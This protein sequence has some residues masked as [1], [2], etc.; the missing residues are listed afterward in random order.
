MGVFMK[1]S[2]LLIGILFISGCDNTVISSDE[3]LNNTSW[4][5]IANEGAYGASNG[6]ISMIDDYGNVYETESIGDIV[7]SFEVYNDKLIVIVNNSH[8]IKIYDI[9]PEGLSMPGIEID[10]ENSS[11]R[12]L[13]VLND[14]IY[15]TNWNTQDVKVFDLFNYT[16]EASI[17]TEGLPEDIMFDGTN[18]WVTIT[19][20]SDWSP[21]T[22][23]SKIDINTNSIIETI[24]VGDG[25]QNLIQH[26]GDIYISRT[27][28]DNSWNA[29]HGSSKIG[30]ETIFNNYGSGVVCGGSVLSYN[31]EVYRSHS[32]GISPLKDNLDIDESGRIGNYNQDEV[33]HVEIIDGDIWFGIRDL[34]NGPGVIKVTDSNGTE[35]LEYSVGINPGDFAVWN[36]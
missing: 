15:F 27:F 6:S 3:N 16:I 20:N 25:P 5:F 30:S 19:M 33:Y 8:K 17:S 4:I 28:Y 1:Q 10:T 18:L 23:V 9:T 21:A 31:G 7:Q 2:I 34:D 13:V 32:G 14:K 26:N 29:Y 35:I 12:E 36:K 22:T 11:P 24:E